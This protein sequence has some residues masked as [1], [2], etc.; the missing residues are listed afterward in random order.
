MY[1]LLTGMRVVE[2]SS[3]IASPQAGLYLAQMG[4]EVIRVDQ[5]GGG[6][7]WKR[8]PLSR[9][10]DSFFWEGFNKAKK[11]VAVDLKNPAGRELVQRLAAAPG[12]NAGLFVTNYPVNGFLSYKTLRT[13]RDD[14]VVAR[15]MGRGDGGTALDFTVN[16]AT[17]FPFM[18]GPEDL[19]EDQPVNHVMPSWDFLT[20]AYT[21]FSLMAGE[22]HRRE[23]GEGK[24]IRIPLMD[25]ALSSIGNYGLIAEVLHEGRNRP[26]YGNE[27]YG[28]LG[29]DFVTADGKRIIIAA[30]TPK[31]WKGVVSVLGIEKEISALEKARGVSFAKEEGIRFQ[32]RD[33]LMPLITEKVVTRYY[34]ELTDALD[35]A[36]CCW[37]PYNT[38]LETAQ[39]PDLIGNNPV[40]EEIVHKSGF[41]YPTPGAPATIEG[42][43]RRPP[44]AAPRLGAD[45][46]EVLGDVLG[47]DDREISQMFDQGVVAGVHA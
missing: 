43:D 35:A 28:A 18:T 8:W 32:H 3:F 12:K 29:R 34:G 42:R 25:M 13:L 41:A 4:A 22:R 44:V 15:V 23:T 45:T 10:G 6:P 47:L 30:L 19:P 39:D 33:A 17:G 5:I 37:G 38:A 16:S 20:A 11:S 24:E 7:D 27:V 40:F 2:A 9:E 31:Q 36:G 46:E 14:I 1:D 21:A 26:R